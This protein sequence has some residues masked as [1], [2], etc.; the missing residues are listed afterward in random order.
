MSFSNKESLPP[1]VLQAVARQIRQLA[2]EPQEGIS[3]VINEQNLADVGAIITGPS[4]TPYEGG[5]FFCKLVSIILLY[6]QSG[7]E[8]F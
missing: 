8:F 4:G 1:R 7:F 3:I 5:S 6:R 2:Q